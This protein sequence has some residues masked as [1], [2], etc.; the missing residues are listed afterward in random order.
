MFPRELLCTLDDGREI[1]DGLNIIC[2]FLFFT[3]EHIE[4]EDYHGR[5]RGESRRWEYFL[6]VAPHRASGL[7]GSDPIPISDSN[8]VVPTSYRR[9]GDGTFVVELVPKDR[10]GKKMAYDN[11]SWPNPPLLFDGA[12]R[13]TIE[14][15]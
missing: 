8:D 13:V 14:L 1:A 15:V 7:S 11:T 4:T 3:A 12:R 5:T 9:L 6:V 2:L 10:W